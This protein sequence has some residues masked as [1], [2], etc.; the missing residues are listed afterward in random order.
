MPLVPFVVG[1]LCHQALLSRPLCRR[2]VIR[3]RSTLCSSFSYSLIC[4][5]FRELI[6]RRKVLQLTVLCMYVYM[7]GIYIYR[8]IRIR[9][10]LHWARYLDIEIEIGKRGT[11]SSSGIGI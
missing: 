7:Q 9:L 6:R 2:F 3:I 1:R 10:I 8:P 5:C 11:G 4:N